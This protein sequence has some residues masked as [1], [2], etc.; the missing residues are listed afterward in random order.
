MKTIKINSPK[1]LL[2][3]LISAISINADA[4]W[5]PPNYVISSNCKTIDKVNLCIFN[6]ESR[7]PFIEVKYKG[8]LID[9]SWGN[10]SAYINVNGRSESFRMTNKNFEETLKINH[11]RNV[12]LCYHNSTITPYGQYK[13]CPN[14]TENGKGL[15]W[16]SEEAPKKEH[17][18]IRESFDWKI[19]LAFFDDNGS[20]DSKFEKNYKFNF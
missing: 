15:D 17:D 5:Y 18:L 16:Y 10:I 4:S 6:K 13:H 7:N 11:A 20:W 2:L 8:Y 14:A 9:K 3:S 19:E 12:H 1:L